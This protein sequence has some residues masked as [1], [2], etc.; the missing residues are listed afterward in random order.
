LIFVLSQSLGNVWVLDHIQDSLG[1]LLK[2]L[3]YRHC[4][5]SLGSKF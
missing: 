2:V 1:L 3:V 4:F 5:F